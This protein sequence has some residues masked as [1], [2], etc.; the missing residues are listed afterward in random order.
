MKWVK[1]FVL[2]DKDKKCG[3]IMK[4]VHFRNFRFPTYSENGFLG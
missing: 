2:I 3:A 4:K 1:P